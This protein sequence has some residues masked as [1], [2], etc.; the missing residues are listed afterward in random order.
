MQHRVSIVTWH[1]KTYHVLIPDI[2]TLLQQGMLLLIPANEN[3][4][5][6][7]YMDLLT[8]HSQLC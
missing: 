3:G 7:V 6:Y 8:T 2:Q 1:S 5:S 4:R